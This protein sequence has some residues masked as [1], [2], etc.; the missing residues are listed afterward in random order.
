MCIARTL[1]LKIRYRAL[2]NCLSPFHITKRQ[3]LLKKKIPLVNASK[4]SYKHFGT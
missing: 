4:S 3:P 1:M 2:E